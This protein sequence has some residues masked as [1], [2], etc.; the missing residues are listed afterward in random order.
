[1]EDL[2]IGSVL[3]AALILGIT[4]FLKDKLML[5]GSAVVVLVAIQGVLFGGLSVAI[6]GGYIPPEAAKWVETV[7]NSLAGILAAMG[8]Y[9]LY[10]RK[11]VGD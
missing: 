4:Q 8:Y 7:V 1:M 6:S 3:V 10:K 9:D 11:N 2:A 5:E